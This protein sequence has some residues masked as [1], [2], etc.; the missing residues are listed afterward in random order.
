MIIEKNNILAGNIIV[1]GDLLIRGKIS[2]E[3]CVKGKMMVEKEGIAEGKMQV[4]RATI[5]GYFKGELKSSGVV[6]IKEGASVRGKIMAPEI[7]FLDVKEEFVEM[8]APEAIRDTVK[9]FSDLNGKPEGGIKLPSV[10]GVTG[11]VIVKPQ[12][13]LGGELNK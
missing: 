10:T 3:V 5:S 7:Y 12:S 6:E 9:P 8:P 13:K 4:E 2:G 11:K 1:E